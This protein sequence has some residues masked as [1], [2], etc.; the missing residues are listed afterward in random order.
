MPGLGKT[1]L[2]AKYS[3]LAYKK[4]YSFVF[5]ISGASVD[6]LN[7]GFSKLLDVI[8]LEYSHGLSQSERCA[9]ARRWMENGELETNREWLLVIDNANQET[10]ACLREIL[11]LGNKRC[12]IL[13]T[14]RTQQVADSLR[15]AFD[16]QHPSIGLDALNADNAIDLFF[17]AAS[18]EQNL[19]DTTELQRVEKVV[20]AVGRLPLAIDQ[21]ASFFKESNISLDKILDTYKSDQAD[22]VRRTSQFPCMR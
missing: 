13:I 4:R 6:K 10:V 3:R 21:V 5:W 7:S 16:E 20:K 22:E 8:S 1:Q 2:A 18:T 17:K 12:S 14:T 15:T 11:P 9:I 19:Q